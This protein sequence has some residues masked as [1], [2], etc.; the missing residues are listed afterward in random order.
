MKLLLFWIKQ[1]GIHHKTT[2]AKWLLVNNLASIRMWV[3]NATTIPLGSP[4]ECA[5]RFRHEVQ[6]WL[7]EQEWNIPFQKSPVVIEI[8]KNDIFYGLENELFV[9][10]K[11]P[12]LARHHPNGGGM[13]AVTA[14]VDDGVFIDR[15]AQVFGQTYVGGQARISGTSKIYDNASIMGNANIRDK[16]IGGTTW[17]FGDDVSC[18]TLGL[19]TDRFSATVKRLQLEHIVVH[20][21]VLANDKGV[22]FKTLAEILRQSPIPRGPNVPNG[23]RIKNTYEI[24]AMLDEAIMRV[25]GGETNGNA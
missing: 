13:V 22:S 24:L 4:N 10:D 2:F 14:A 9:F 5:E 16:E 19:P 11:I 6:T 3:K 8:H 21:F 25:R 23:E 17:D 7:N 18:L 1:L 15:K 12:L 20:K